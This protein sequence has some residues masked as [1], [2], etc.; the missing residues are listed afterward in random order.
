MIKAVFFDLDN[1]LYHLYP[2]HEAAWKEVLSYAGNELSIAEDIFNEA[3]KRE[4]RRCVALLGKNSAVIHNRHIRF[5]KTLQ[6]LNM[7]VFPHADRMYH[8]YWN[9]IFSEMKPDPGAVRLLEELRNRGIYVAIATNMTAH[10]Q[11]H[12]IEKLGIEGLLNAVITSEEAG[13]EKPDPNFF[14][15]C[16]GEAG[17]LTQEC[18]FVGDSPATDIEGAKAAGMRGV[19]YAPEGRIVSEEGSIPLEQVEPRKKID[20]RFPDII[21]NYENLEQ[22]IPILLEEQ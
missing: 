6:R 10:V 19:L 2:L 8:I 16:A 15:Y 22:I 3:V 9:R 11:Y 18:A 12:K 1:T 7:P 5:Q 21:T 20:G 4:M 17:L 13:L 14:S